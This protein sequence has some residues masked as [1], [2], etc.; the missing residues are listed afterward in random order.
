MDWHKLVM[1]M[2]YKSSVDWTARE[3]SSCVTLSLWRTLCTSCSSHYPS[4][5]NLE[6][7]CVHAWENPACL[8][9]FLKGESLQRPVGSLPN[10]GTCP[11]CYLKKLVSLQNESVCF[12][13][14]FMSSIEHRETAEDAFYAHLFQKHGRLQG[15]FSLI[16][17]LGCVL[18]G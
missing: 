12:S 14:T 3:G 5:Q 7:K 1:P 2:L 6:L 8:M 10:C 9:C 13:L 15:S 16:C 18:E 17:C 4:L 11:C